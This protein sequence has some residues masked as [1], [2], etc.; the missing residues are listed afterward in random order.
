[1]NARPIDKI[2]GLEFER[3]EL[4]KQ[5]SEEGTKR[6]AENAKLR[7]RIEE[8]ERDRSDIVAENERSNDAVVEIKTE[9]VKIRNENEDILNLV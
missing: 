2:A 9:V 7:S 6:E 3:T 1:E 5:V 4:L 8:L